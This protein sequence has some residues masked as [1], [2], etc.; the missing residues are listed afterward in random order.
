MILH[1]EVGQTPM[2]EAEFD[3]Y[4]EESL[5]G[6]SAHYVEAMASNLE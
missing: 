1:S 3:Q 6:S 5:E 2:T 4:L